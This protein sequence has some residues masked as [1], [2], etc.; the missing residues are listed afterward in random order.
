MCNGMPASIAAAAVSVLNDEPACLP[1]PPPAAPSA[2]FTC[3]VVQSRPPTI[4]RTL[5]ESFSSATT[6]A[7]GSPG[8]LST[9][10]IALSASR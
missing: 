3:D 2:R 9:E 8:W 5:P 7:A 4:A 10:E 6:A 1:V